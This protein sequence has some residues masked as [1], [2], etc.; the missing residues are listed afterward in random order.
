MR[1]SGKSTGPEIPRR[2]AKKAP[3][4]YY[5]R[6]LALKKPNSEY[7]VCFSRK[8]RVYVLWNCECSRPVKGGSR[9]SVLLI[10]R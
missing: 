4:P 1:I 6:L 10:L 8:R 5:M 9:L 7:Q 2:Y 3:D